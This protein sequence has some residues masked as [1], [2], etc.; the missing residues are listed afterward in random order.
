[1]GSS[2]HRLPPKDEPGGEEKED[3]IQFNELEHVVDPFLPLRGSDLKDAGLEL[4]QLFRREELE[5][6]AEFYKQALRLD[7][8]DEDAKYNLELLTKRQDE[9]KKDQ[10][11]R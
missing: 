11:N 5:K 6:A 4:E 3:H 8:K 10:Q 2:S 1:M 7:S 9:Q